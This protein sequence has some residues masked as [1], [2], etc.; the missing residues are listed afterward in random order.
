[1]FAETEGTAFVHIAKQRRRAKR[2]EEKERSAPP[3]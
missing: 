3:S 2:V 1:M